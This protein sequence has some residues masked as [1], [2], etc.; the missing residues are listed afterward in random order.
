M[1]KINNLLNILQE[2][3]EDYFE[4][5]LTEFDVTKILIDNI[6]DIDI[7]LSEYREIKGE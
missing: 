5:A 6:D 4:G 3:K 7:F 1:K 2:L